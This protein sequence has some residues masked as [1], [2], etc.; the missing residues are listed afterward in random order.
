MGNIAAKN[1][2]ARF[3]WLKKVQQ[4][5]TLIKACVSLMLDRETRPQS[6]GC[7]KNQVS[8]VLKAA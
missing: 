2:R 4:M 1:A 6:S 3:S 7:R 8:A 5:D